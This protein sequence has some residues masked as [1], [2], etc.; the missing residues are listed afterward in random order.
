MIGN[1][2]NTMFRSD[3]LPPTTASKKVKNSKE[4]QYAMLDSLEHIAKRQFME[5]M[6]F[7]DLYRMMDNEMSYQEL[8]DVVP[9]L[10]S[11]QDLLNG[12][13]IPTFLKH[14]D[15]LGSIVRDIVGRH[16]DIQDKFY[17]Q[18]V[19]DLFDNDYQRH[20]TS[21][22]IKE[23]DEQIG[24]IID[25]FMVENNLNPDGREFNS[26]EEQQQF[27]MELERVK[28]EQT[29]K[30]MKK[31]KEKSFKTIGMQWAEITLKDDAEKF[32]LHNLDAENMTDKVLTG[33]C[34]RHFI[35]HP[36]GYDL[37]NWSPKQVFTSKEI[38][39]RFTQDGE[40]VG[41]L[42]VE[43]PAGVIKRFGHH[44]D[45]KTQK[46][47]LG[48]RDGWRNFV[49]DGVFSDT[50]QNNLR[51]GGATPATVP[52]SNYFDYN[53]YLALQDETGVPMG[54]YTEFNKDGTQ[55]TRDT[56]LPRYGAP[57]TASS[58]FYAKVLRNDFQHRSDLCEVV[59]AY[60]RCYDLY[61]FLTYED[62]NGDLVT[63]EVTEDI[64]PELLKE[65]G[66]KQIKNSTLVEVLEKAPEPG[67]LVWMY[68]PVIYEGVKILC[69]N[70]HDPI[71]LYFRECEHQIKGN[72]MFDVKLPVSGYMGKGVA[73]RI[74][75]YQI[76]HNLVMNQIVNM[77]E[78]EIGIF[79]LLDVALIP[80]D[81]EGYGDAKEALYSMRDIITETSILPVQTSGDAD[82]NQNHFNQFASYNLT[83]R[84]QIEYRI[85]LAEYYKQL[86]YEQVG[87]NPQMA[88]TPSKYETAEGIRLGQELSI[89]QL[90]GIY[91]EFSEYRQRTLEMHLSVAQYSQSS[92]TDISVK[93]T[94][95]DGTIAWLRAT[96]P[97]LP[98]RTLGLV[99]TENSS[100]RKELEMFK[101]YLLNNNTLNTDVVEVARLISSDAMAQAIEIAVNSQEQRQGMEEQAHQRQMQMIQEDAK[102]REAAEDKRFQNEIVLKEIDGKIK[103]AVAQ[104]NA[105]GRAAD[106]DSDTRGIEEIK[107]ASDASIKELGIQSKQTIEEAKTD[108]LREKDGMDQSIKLKEL[109][110]KAQELKVKAEMKNK[111]VQI[112]AMNKN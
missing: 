19:G 109:A 21:R 91:D 23:I 27:M 97:S 14:Y 95:D 104:T 72:H 7:V 40:Y 9:Y 54:Q 68:R 78:K 41:R 13:D 16:R 50:I 20:Q 98:F 73:E 53:Y 24:L 6:K 47:L 63:E 108:R 48:G 34:F 28:E 36:N 71:Y 106:K 5:N 1:W 101:Q 79:F 59:E 70:V 35:I 69:P 110:L 12:A 45:T 90:A 93:M 94:R 33:R 4:W 18:E 42:T 65:K 38:G 25:K 56:Y 29:P 22:I 15:I 2:S 32:K 81:V 75:P 80:S 51:S 26:P 31:T 76:A 8:K 62:E 77:L 30:G 100:K 52:F 105:L 99:P 39:S 111:D 3:D 37:E 60:V 85:R 46:Q 44:I 17:V 89:A 57:Q 82:K 87:S 102:L 92:N 107:A 74:L 66:I 83:Y 55:T 88:V 103:V 10:E 43:T 11:L 64:L 49:G 61:G 96:D 84:E 86:A 112:A 58:K 67:T